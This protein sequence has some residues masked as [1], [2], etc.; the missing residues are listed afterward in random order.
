MKSEKK[1]MTTFE[2]NIYFI[3]F[4]VILDLLIGDPR[5]IPHPVIII[6][7][8]I[9]V[10]ERRWNRNHHKRMKGLFLLVGITCGAYLTISGI[11]WILSLIHP[12]LSLIAEV[13]FISTTI[14]MK[15]LQQAGL[16]VMKPLLQND[17]PKAR[18]KLSYIVGRDTEDLPKSEIVRGTV[19]TVAENTV[20]GIISPIFWAIIGGAPLA[21]AYRA[22]NTLDS[23]VGYKNE[24]YID[25][26]WASARCDDLANYI[27]A[28]LTAF[29]MWIFA[30]FIPYSKRRNA[31]LITFRDAKKHP[32]PNGGWPEAMTAGLLGVILGGEN[33]YQGKVSYRAEMG[34]YYRPLEI[35]DIKKSIVYM[36]GAWIVFILTLYAGVILFHLI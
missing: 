26:G 30:V 36:H 7:K 2:L 13:Y 35:D 20:D 29:F 10:I 32:S 8:F 31:L 12:L 25:F 11:I 27:P 9:D 23:M 3:A 28:R 4:A 6:G 24:R 19:E 21:M 16:E 33:K 1:M 15:G 18:L 34:E 14:A 17:L 5:W 22:I